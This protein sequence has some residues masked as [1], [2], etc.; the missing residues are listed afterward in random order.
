MLFRIV[1]S[2][3]SL[4]CLGALALFMGV[5]DINGSTSNDT[6]TKPTVNV[7]STSSSDSSGE[8][9]VAPPPQKNHK[10]TNEDV[11]KNLKF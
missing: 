10:Q 6:S 11:L 2:V 1:G 3:V 4:L 7:P 8:K 9:S 5:V